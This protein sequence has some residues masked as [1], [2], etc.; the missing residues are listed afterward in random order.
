MLQWVKINGDFGVW[1]APIFVCFGGDW[2]AHWGDGSLTHGHVAV[3]F[4][5]FQASNIMQ[6]LPRVAEC[7][8]PCHR[9][10]EIDMSADCF[11]V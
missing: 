4:L 1:A 10:K 2:D 5:A 6:P 11:R 8:G 9:P 3:T 7:R